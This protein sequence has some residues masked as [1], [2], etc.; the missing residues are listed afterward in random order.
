MYV[1]GIKDKITN[2]IACQ[3]TDSLDYLLMSDK[4]Q[5]PTLNTHCPQK[6]FRKSGGYM[7]IRNIFG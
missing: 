4:K 6:R 1:K 7:F 2:G 3:I 5:L